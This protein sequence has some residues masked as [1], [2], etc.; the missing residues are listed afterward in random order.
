MKYSLHIRVRKQ[1]IL[2]EDL[3][4]DVKVALSFLPIAGI[5]EQ[6]DVTRTIDVD[7]DLPDYPLEQRAIDYLNT[8][9][10]NASPVRV[11]CITREENG[12]ET[13]ITPEQAQRD[14]AQPEE[15]AS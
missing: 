9:R 7:L 12:V 3:P 6:T 4:L 11:W 10:L 14:T 5:S 1:H 2:V 15:K 13:H 8:S